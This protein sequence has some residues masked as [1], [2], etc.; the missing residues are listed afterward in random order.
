M[1]KII[2]LGFIVLIYTGCISSSSK[3]IN[4]DTKS[5]FYEVELNSSEKLTVLIKTLM[6]DEL[7]LVKTEYETSQDFQQR[8]KENKKHIQNV[9]VKAITMAHNTIYSKLYID[10]KLKY[11]AD[12]EN[13]YGYIK[14]TK[15]DF[16]ESVTIKVPIELAKDFKQKIATV[17]VQLSFE[18]DHTLLI[19][20]SI[21]LK[22]NDETYIAHPIKEN[23][24]YQPLNIEIYNGI[25]NSEEKSTTNI[26]KID[27]LEIIEIVE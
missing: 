16:N 1:I 4:N 12:T 24:N 27:D 17:D 22:N 9:R 23:Y 7:K 15:G 26:D 13:F 21:I 3:T 19:L 14:S 25:L 2:I 8:V 20:K 11:N 18:Y 10:E 5:L 6:E